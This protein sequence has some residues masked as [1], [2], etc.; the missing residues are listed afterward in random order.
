[1]RDEALVGDA[2]ARLMR[3]Y[4]LDDERIAEL[5][6]LGR[7][8]C[9]SAPEL[10][11]L[12]RREALLSHAVDT[13]QRPLVSAGMSEPQ[14]QLLDALLRGEL[15]RD[16]LK[17]L[18]ARWA[19][20]VNPEELIDRVRLDCMRLHE[21]LRVGALRVYG[22][23][24]WR[25]EM[26]LEALERLAFLQLATLTWI[27]DAEG[28]N[29]APQTLPDYTPFMEKLG[30]QLAARQADGHG[31]AVLTVDCGVISRL[32][33]LWGFHV[34]DAA[35]TRIVQRLRMGVLRARDVLGEIGRDEFACVLSTISGPGVALLA[36]QK[37]L[38]MLAAPVM[39][40]ETEIFARPAV[41]VAIYPDNGAD[42]A[43]LLLRSK[44]ACHAARDSAD[45]VV[46]YRE[47]QENPRLQLLLYESK[48][49]AAIDEGRLELVYQPQF[50]PR[51]LRLHGVEAL[52]RWE[53]SEFGAISTHE[54]IAVAESAG[55]INEI[56]W[57]VLNNAL[58]QCAEFRARGLEVSVSVNLSPNNLREP[59]LPDFIDR[60]LR[61]WDVPPQ[62]LVVEITETAVLAAPELV[63]ETLLR[64][65]S[66]GVRLSI[67]DF[68]TGYSSMYYLASM[69]LDEMKIDLSFVRDM[70]KVPQHQRIVHSMI[71]LGHSLG[72]TVVAEG[73]EGQDVVERLAELGCDRVQGYFTSP[74]LAPAELLR[75]YA[76]PREGDAA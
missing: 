9:E 11:S 29:P 43:S 58:R 23:D 36:A 10:A 72:L 15:D 71:E 38:R 7:A 14:R 33:G 19:A 17:T 16:R 63:S 76:P 75:R 60:G 49:R 4:G 61:T 26:A 27:A 3:E 62:A 12:A 18:L 32:D 55:L 44:I 51:G 20:S 8:V 47:K 48:L 70:L 54:A 69:P 31:L 21:L 65:K 59:D 57:W 64:L 40:G 41:G 30:E 24:P 6:E 53:D 50:E 52:L 56:T 13:F 28:R 45:R 22:A 66:L 35:R 25:C 2:A 42:A 5:T 34:G 39:V 67:D 46:V 73:V 37:I 68:G 74:P 1:M